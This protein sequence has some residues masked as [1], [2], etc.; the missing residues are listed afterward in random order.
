MYK[1]VEIAQKWNGRR[2]NAGEQKLARAK[3]MKAS[4]YRKLILAPQ[5]R[6]RAIVQVRMAGPVAPS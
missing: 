5:Q 4:P 3:I 6:R 2:K 1:T